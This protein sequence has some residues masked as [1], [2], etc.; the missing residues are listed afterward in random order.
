MSGVLNGLGSCRRVLKY[1]LLVEFENGLFYLAWWRLVR[2]R[3]GVIVRHL[4][5]G[6]LS[7]YILDAWMSWVAH[8]LRGWGV[9]HLLVV[10]V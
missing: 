9:G 6:W 8:H 4:V 5:L 3:D 2:G 1:S 7:G 10:R